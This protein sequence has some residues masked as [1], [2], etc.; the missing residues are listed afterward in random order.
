ML[1]NILVE[2][3][4]KIESTKKRL[5]KTYY[6]AELL[7]KTS[8]KEIDKVLLLL[9]GRI[10][11]KHSEQKLGVASQLI[12]KAINS[13][14]GFSERE[15]TKLW[16]EMGD[17]GDVAAHV[18]KKRKQTSLYSETL[19]IEKVFSTLKNLAK[20]EGVGSNE[21]KNNLIAELLSSA[22]PDETKFIIRTIL[23]VMRVG[24][25]RGTLRDAIAWVY[26]GKEIGISYDEEGNIINLTGEPKKRYK[27]Y[28]DAIQ[29]GY[30]IT[31]EFSIVIKSIKKCG[32][33][34]V[35]EIALLPGKP[36][37]V[38]LYI[39][40]E[41]IDNAIKIVGSPAAFEFKLDGFRLQCHKRDNKILLFTRRLEDVTAQFQEVVESLE[42]LVEADS[43]ILEGEAVGYDPK[44]KR[45]LPFQKISQR[46]KR[47]Y[48]I[49]EI[50]KQYPV[51]LN[52]FDLIYLNG[53]SHLAT[54]FIRRRELLKEIVSEKK[55]EIVL[56]K[57]LV[58]SEK[59]R[60]EEFYRSALETGQEG[61]M[62]KNL[63]AVYK[64]G[65]RIG[66]GVKIKPTLEPLDLVIVKAE[67]GEGKRS[68]WLTSYVM[69]CKL[70][71]EEKLLEIGKVSTGL[72][73]KEEE[74]L[75]FKELT[76]LLKP[77]I[78]KSEGKEVYVQPKIIL[79][80]AYE[81]IQKSPTYSSGYALRF[82]TI[83]RLR[84]NEKDIK[85]I[86]T[87]KDVERLYTQ[88]R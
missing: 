22:S 53:K 85:E 76:Q 47:K 68:G 50:A 57:Q 8:E 82:P 67:Y 80:V 23:E 18:T 44:T 66:Y 86:N 49:S 16:K 65:A 72:K 62:A 84:S 42:K 21:K 75:S 71:K 78:K 20:A 28:I 25:G 6:V 37:N 87:L 51:E 63:D 40:A 52:L 30:D 27:E 4:K 11:P 69:A 31:N 35:E 46:I 36:L 33:Q 29:R 54:K 43:Y 15:I 56:V 34:G 58:T 77:L 45:Y 70:E 3:Y 12:I 26:F 38:M 60:A 73:E 64:P 74:G 2:T 83:K 32:I 39:K 48:N 5:K 59:K 88:Q 19:T 81:E 41:D 79:E 24:I 1:Y 13:A 10:F 61:I 17:L 9:Q 7:K 55:G 14:S